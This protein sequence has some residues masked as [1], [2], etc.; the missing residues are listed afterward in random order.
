MS[1]FGR[2]WLKRIKLDWQIIKSYCINSPL[3]EIIDKHSHLFRS[4]LR[5]LKG[6]KAKICVPSNAQL[7]YYKPRPVSYLLR[8]KVDQELEHVLKAGIISPF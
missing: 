2:N 6:M 3:D 1:L 4:E 8:D 7:R 5:K